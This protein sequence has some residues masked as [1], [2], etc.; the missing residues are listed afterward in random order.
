[1]KVYFPSLTRIPRKSFLSMAF[2]MGW[3]LLYLFMTTGTLEM[4][5]KS[6]H[7]LSHSWKGE[8]E[9]HDH[10]HEQHLLHR[11]E[12]PAHAHHHGALYNLFSGWVKWN[13]KSSDTENKPPVW[14][15]WQQIPAFFDKEC[16]PDFVNAALPVSN[17][18]SPSSLKIPP[19]SPPPQ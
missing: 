13:K 18:P 2:L 1:M 7:S 4:G 17:L 16:S 8:V 11:V 14:K 19:L 12:A 9:L 5:L 15:N 6:I 3:I 10:D